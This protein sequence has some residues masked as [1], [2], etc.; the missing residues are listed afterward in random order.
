MSGEQL[1]KRTQEVFEHLKICAAE[2]Q[3][4]TYGQLA[5]AVNGSPRHM[6]RPLWYIREQCRER[7]LP[8]LNALS[9]NAAKGRP[10]DNYLPEDL[11]NEGASVQRWRDMV[12]Q[13]FAYDWNGVELQ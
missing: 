3:I 8:W 11:P 12:E 6:S 2:R 4:V 1:P 10:G 13:V 9:V 7:G 5:K